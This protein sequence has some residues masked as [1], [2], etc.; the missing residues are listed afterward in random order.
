MD[1]EQVDYGATDGR[2]Y[3]GF[4]AKPARAARHPA[5]L[6]AHEAPGLLEHSKRVAR[7]LADVGYLAFAIDYVGEGRVMTT[8]SEVGAQVGEWVAHPA[9]IRLACQ[10]AHD[11]LLAR[12]DVDHTRVAAFGYCFGAQALVEYARTGADLVAVVGFHP[13]M[14]INRPVE[15][16][17]IRARL[18]MFTG[19]ADPITSLAQRA[20]FEEEMDGAGVYWRMMVYG[21]VP[22]S[23]TNAD[24]G[25]AAV[26]GVAYDAVA[27]DDSWIAALRFL[28]DC[29][30][31]P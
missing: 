23:F 8:M 28:D 13:G 17:G 12:I 1:L 7:K 15:S 24:A 19:S 5:V 21:G 29:G 3:R 30:M 14:S 18:M 2:A 22:H 10:A 9:A 26:P 6:V 31:A 25:E 11:L 16:A 20:A 4:I 27:D